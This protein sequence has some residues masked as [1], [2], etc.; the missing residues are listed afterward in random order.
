MAGSEKY[1]F[2]YDGIITVITDK[3]TLT[4]PPNKVR[5]ERNAIFEVFMEK[6]EQGVRGGGIDLFQI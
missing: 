1:S 5:G 3:W 2:F 6:I 4:G